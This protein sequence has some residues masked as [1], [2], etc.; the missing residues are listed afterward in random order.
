MFQEMTDTIDLSGLIIASSADH[1][2]DNSRMTIFHRRKDTRQSRNRFD[3]IF[4]VLTLNHK[5]SSMSSTLPSKYK[6][7]ACNSLTMG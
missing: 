1:D 7:I 6:E 4:H 2:L 5:N 3:T